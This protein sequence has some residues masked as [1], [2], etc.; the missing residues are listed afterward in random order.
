MRVLLTGASR[1]IGK[2]IALRLAAPGVELAL[3]ASAPG[4]E[5]DST[6]AE[7]ER[8]GGRGVGLAGDLSE[9]DVPAR[10]VSEAVAALGGIDH[11]VANAG[12]ARPG[13]LDGHPVEAWDY[14]FA[15]NVRAT[16]LMATHGRP[17]L[18]ESGGSVVA[19]GS[20]SGMAPHVGLA[21]YSASKAALHMLCRQLAQEW[22]PDHIRVN[23]VSPGFILNERTSVAYEDEG[24]LQARLGMI[25]LARLG[26]TE[27]D[28]AEAVAF[29]IGDGA[30]YLTGQLLT[31][32]G[33]LS[34]AVLS[35]DPVAHAFLNDGSSRASRNAST[36]KSAT[37]G[38]HT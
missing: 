17:H 16:W 4:P 10:L 34:D 35:S 18:R 11:L 24:V 30:S 14:V 38:V 6:I 32:D 20:I 9:P 2:G 28:V 12:L 33:G 5:L 36:V 29:L 27:R 25:P 7:V 15:V 3:C 8:L 21:S 31:V 22:A 13:A 23:V 37:R 26:H 1:G 19:L